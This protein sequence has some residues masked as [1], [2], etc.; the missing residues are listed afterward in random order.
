MTTK[1]VFE[2]ITNERGWY[3]PLGYSG[4]K[5]RNIK[6]QFLKGK[7]STDVM[8]EIIQLLGYKVIQEKKWI[9]Q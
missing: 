8:E 6:M 4:S 1:E 7:L 2:E 9:K 5:G 3:I